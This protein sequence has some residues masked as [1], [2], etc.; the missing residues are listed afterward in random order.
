M[1]A[2]NRNSPEYFSYNN[3]VKRLKINPAFLKKHE[4]IIR[5]R[6]E[7]ASAEIQMG[8]ESKMENAD[9]TGI[10]KCLQLASTILLL[11]T[12]SDNIS[13]ELAEVA[14]ENSNA[15]INDID[16]STLLT[17]AVLY[18]LIEQKETEYSGAANIPVKAIRER[19]SKI[20][21]LVGDFWILKLKIT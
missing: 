6:F 13:K 10:N 16:P 15:G 18:Y 9:I 17:I 7:A 14:T 5:E 11:G 2:L 20:R 21:W 4:S 3:I 19:F 8:L 1:S 12:Q